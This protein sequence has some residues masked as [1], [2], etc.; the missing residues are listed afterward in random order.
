VDAPLIDS[1]GHV[2]WTQTRTGSTIY[3]STS[4][5][6][7]EGATVLR[8]PIRLK[9]TGALAVPLLMLTVVTTLEVVGTVQDVREIR[10]QADLARAA[11]GPS[12]VITQLQNERRWSA[13]ELVGGSDESGSSYEDVRALTDQAVADLRGEIDRKGEPIAAAFQPAFDA[14]A[15]LEDVRTAIDQNT[16]PRTPQTNLAFSQDVFDRYSAIVTAL[17]DATTRVSLAVDDTEL[18]RGAELADVVARQIDT[19]SV[20]VMDLYVTEQLTEGGVNTPS[21]IADLSVLRETFEQNADTVRTAAGPYARI[22]ADHFPVDLTDQL[23]DVVDQAIATSRVDPVALSAALDGP[24]RGGYTD[25][26]ESIADAITTRADELTTAATSRQRRLVG[27]AMLVLV[28]ATGV[29]WAVSRSITRPLRSLTHQ[30]KDVADRRLPDS[31]A[32][33]LAAPL[34][35]DV[36]MPQVTSVRVRSRDEVTDLVDALNT[37]QGSA[38]ELAVEQALLRRN[39]ADSFVNLGRRNQNL[40]GRQLDFITELEANEADADS[41]AS[42]FRLDH[43]ATRMRRNAESL[44]VLAGIEPS[45]QSTAPVQLGNVVRAALGEVEDYQ[46]VA[47]LD[48]EPATIS[49]SAAADLAHL[50]AELIENALV[51]SAPDRRVDIRGRHHTAPAPGRPDAAG[52]ARTYVLTLVDAGP[53]MPAE[54]LIA[55]NRRLAGVERFTI[56]PSRYLGHYVAGRL[57]TRHGITIHLDSTAGSGTAAYVSLPSSMLTCEVRFATRGS[58]SDG[59]RVLE[60]SDRSPADATTVNG[61]ARTRNAQLPDTQPTALHRAT[62]VRPAASRREQSGSAEEVYGF[63]TSFTIGVQRGLDE[64]RRLDQHGWPQRGSRGV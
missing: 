12:G 42:L 29:T 59:V 3:R 41:L 6:R 32:D 61:L 10:T 33:I 53:G 52:G 27:L 63:L 8:V 44:L 40:I 7:N 4:S 64:A 31:V 35:E 13:V 21:E 20:L 58:S 48:V 18:R 15:A 30:A 36:V 9:L 51:F 49:G 28:S 60:T 16:T 47:L 39:I 57:A 1:I 55:A 19:M 56:A 11:I 2:Y 43:L 50:L 45:R 14:L 26:Q 17:F 22:A 62:A 38:L 54:Q 5:R 34:G 24:D 37:V 25:Y 23:I 46:R